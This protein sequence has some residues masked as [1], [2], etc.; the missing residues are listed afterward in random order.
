MGLKN[1]L[2]SLSSTPTKQPNVFRI[3]SNQTD[4]PEEVSGLIEPQQHYFYV[5]V[6]EM[7]LSAQRKWFIAVEPMV[8]CLTKYNYGASTVDNPFVVG[9]SLIQSNIQNIPQGM[10]FYDTRVAGLHPFSGGTFSFAVVLCQ[11]EVKNY[12]A[13]SLEFIQKVSGVFSKS[14]TLLVGKY[15][16]IAN[17][18]IT[19]I[20]NLLNSGELQPL[21]GIMQ[22]FDSDSNAG[23]TPG[24]FLM[25]DKAAQN[26]DESKFFV[27]ENRLHYGNDI[28]SAKLFYK[29]EGFRDNDYVLYSIKKADDRDDIKLLPIYQSYNKI[30]EELKVNEVSNDQK[31]KIK[32]MLRVLN[33]EMRQSPDLTESHAIKLMN[34]FSEDVGKMIEPKFNWGAAPKTAATDAWTK[35]DEKIMAL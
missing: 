32:N 25:M 33:I 5:T 1:F 7:F 27:K 19:G 30:L 23:L 9:R 11:A 29:S 34:K 15:I 14:I 17:V 31:T 20:D 35:L 13:N 8:I 21:F 10:L 26:I 18:I 24:Y 3:K 4:H 12:L 28:D 6:N 2:K 16:E 22:G